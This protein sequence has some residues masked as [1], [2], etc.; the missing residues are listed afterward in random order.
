VAKDGKPAKPV[1][2]RRLLVLRQVFAG[3]QGG[4][5]CYGDPVR[6]GD[7]IVVPV[8]RVSTAGGGG[9][10]SGTGTV[11]DG[12]DGTG[13]G[14]G[15]WVEAAPVGFIDMGPEGARFQGIPDPVGTA[16]AVKNVMGGV[17]ALVGVAVGLRS[18][19]QQRRAGLPS[20]RRLLQR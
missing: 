10:G 15:A 1:K 18:L 16:R 12:G 13:G 6:N 9:F 20:P 7:R 4:R 8:A 19:R 11:A 5:L 2:D 17:T 3:L 14:G